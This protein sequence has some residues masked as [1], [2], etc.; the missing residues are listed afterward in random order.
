[1][2]SDDAILEEAEPVCDEPVSYDGEIMQ[3]EMSPQNP[4]WTNYVLSLFRPNE[5]NNNF[6][7]TVKVMICTEFEDVDGCADAGP[8]NTPTKYSHHPVAVAESRAEGRAYRKLLRLTNIISAE[9]AVSNDEIN[10][11]YEAINSSQIKL[12]DKMC[13]EHNINVDKWLA[14]H[15]IKLEDFS[16]THKSKAQ[17][18]CAELNALRASGAIPED[19]LGFDLNW[20]NL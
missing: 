13:S 3:E 11:I 6:H 18:L 15:N 14:G 5:L 19:I 1:M 9:E 2:E 7:A 16:R 4:D 17:D 12:I 20:R 10:D 8:N